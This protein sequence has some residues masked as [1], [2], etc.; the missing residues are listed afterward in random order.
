MLKNCKNE[1]IISKITNQ[2]PFAYLIILLHESN[3]KHMTL[4]SQLFHKFG[5]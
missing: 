5:A 3:I 2:W 4:L 1:M